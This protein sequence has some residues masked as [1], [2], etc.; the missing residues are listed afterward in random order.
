M[1][2]YKNRKYPLSL[3]VIGFVT[4]ILFH[5][6][7]LF[8]PAVILLLVGIFVKLCLILGAILLLID[9]ILSL[10]EQL[11][12]RHTFLKESNHPGFRAFQE[13]MSKD[14]NWK[15]NMDAFLNREMADDEGEIQSDEKRQS[16]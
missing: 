14:G 1:N 8:I 15:E 10:I 6:F 3:F 7:W 9:I 13:A 16:H 12:I 11:L 5:F 4:N 2:N